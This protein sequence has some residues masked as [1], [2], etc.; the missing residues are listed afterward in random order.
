MPGQCGGP[1]VCRLTWLEQGEKTDRF[2]SF[3]LVVGPAPG[4]AMP[5]TYYEG[6]MKLTIAEQAFLRAVQEMT[7]ERYI[8]TPQRLRT[9]RR[10]DHVRRLRVFGGRA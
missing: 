1:Q 5:G 6:A 9:L 8:W 2:S 4:R 7:M 3:K 10:R